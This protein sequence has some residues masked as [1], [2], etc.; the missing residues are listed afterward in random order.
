MPT[1]L[2]AADRT[3]LQRAGE[4]AVVAERRGNRPFGALIV[5]AN[6]KT[7]AAAEN[8]VVTEDDI[9]AHAEINAVRQACRAGL[10]RELAGATIYASA[11]PCPMCA[12]AILRFGLSRIVYGHS[13]QSMATT[14][15]AQAELLH[16]A[17]RDIAALAPRK[18]EVIGPCDSAP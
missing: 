13:W 8:S 14:L 5:G 1:T 15:G 2:T 12:G 16:V 10:Q 11:E 6:G 4:L 18:V 7:L 3:H 17:S 9:A